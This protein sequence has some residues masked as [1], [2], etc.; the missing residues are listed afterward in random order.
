M[1]IPAIRQEP[2]AAPP[3]PAA[4]AAAASE[5]QGRTLG[6]LYF[7]Q[8]HY[9]EALRI[10][11]EIVATSGSD[12]DLARTGLANVDNAFEPWDFGRLDPSRHPLRAWD[13]KRDD[14]WA[15]DAPGLS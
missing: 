11:D 14:P 2:P 3:A 5:P 10:Y 6:D 13:K 4:A 8:G 12:P 15:G 7:A 1:P 9:A